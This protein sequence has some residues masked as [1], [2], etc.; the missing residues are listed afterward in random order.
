[1]AKIFWEFIMNQKLWQFICIILFSSFETWRLEN[2][3]NLYKV[4]HYGTDEATFE[5]KQPDC[6][7][8]IGKRWLADRHLFYK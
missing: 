5:Y 1:M 2:W 4:M 3:D 6:R 7:G 8:G